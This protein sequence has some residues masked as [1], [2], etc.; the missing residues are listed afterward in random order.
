MKLLVLMISLFAV[1]PLSAEIIFE[2]RFQGG[3]LS[4]GWGT[5]P[6]NAVVQRADGP[7][8]AD[9]ISVS[10]DKEGTAKVSVTLPVKEL[11]GKAVIVD[12]WI[13][14]ERVK[15]GPQHYNNAKLSLSWKVDGR[16]EYARV[17]QSDFSG[18]FSWKRRAYVIVLPAAVEQVYLSIGLENC[19]GTAYFGPISVRVDDRVKNQ[20]DYDKLITA[21]ER[22][23]YDAILA[24][25]AFEVTGSR[26]NG[27]GVNSGGAA[28]PPSMW[29]DKVRER[30]LGMPVPSVP[31][32]KDFA[33]SLARAMKDHAVSLRE[34]VSE[35]D[36]MRRNIFVREIGS[37]I[38]KSTALAAASMRP[39]S[40]SCAPKGAAVSATSLMFGH[41][42]NWGEFGE[43]YDPK[44]E[45]FTKEFMDLFTPMGVSMLR[46][47][48]GCN[49]DTFDWRG[50]VGPIE[51]RPVQFYYNQGHKGPV[52]FGVDDILRFCEREKI[53]PLLTTAFLWDEP[54]NLADDHPRTK[55][56]PWIKDYLKTAPER[57]QLA[58]DWVEYCNSSIDTPMGKLRAK[59]GHPLPYNVK[60]WEIANEPFG[61]DPLG[62][63]DPALYAEV[64]PKYAAAMKARDPSIMAGLCVSE[65]SSNWKRD[66]LKAIP[67][68]DFIQTHY[69]RTPKGASPDDAGL[70]QQILMLGREVVRTSAELKANM[71]EAGREIPVMV[72]EYNMGAG[73]G[74]A[75]SILTSLATAVMVADMLSI[76]IEDP[77]YIG[78]QHWCLYENY[79]FTPF[80]GPSRGKT[81]PY[82]FRPQWEV[83]RI[84]AACRSEKRIP[85]HASSIDVS[86]LAYDRGAEYG[87][88]LI[89]RSADTWQKLAV[90]LPSRTQDDANAMVLT[91]GE[92]MSGNDGMAGLVT[93]H[94]FTCTDDSILLPP[95][96]VCG[97]IRKKK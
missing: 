82:Y 7:A 5:F 16:M 24:R 42:I 57:I 71:R 96:A 45:S 80:G 19:T 54:K 8:G 41:N 79:F 58:A 76:I 38:E 56:D 40:V 20:S 14:A 6:A 74:L 26:G 44:S 47:P 72:T 95:A 87:I 86:V 52:V 68:A 94:E 43:V 51:K 12:G 49:A 46:Y 32:T 33:A 63:C 4:Q 75:G 77:M 50:A 83:Y 30:I 10:L 84:F 29:N 64:F 73:G 69:Y 39:V 36:E 13:K 1:I 2:E 23:R 25:G 53:T 62:S 11:A 59:N 60:Y 31:G 81:R 88:I 78:A 21:E 66:P 89:N 97:I 91:A 34:R 85:M 55:K 17:A 28:I 90:T 3:A 65:I 70:A 27:I 61:P 22:K 15:T 93:A 18:S 67:H 37:L 35:I 48:G 92:P 9:A